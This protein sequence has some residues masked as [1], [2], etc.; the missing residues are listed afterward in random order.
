MSESQDPDAPRLRPELTDSFAGAMKGSTG[1]A[2]TVLRPS[3]KATID[4]RLVDVVSDG[5]F[6]PE[7]SEIE[8]VQVL[9]NRIVVREA[10]G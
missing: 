10:R 3:G 5:G 9:G 8:V 6:I 2:M 7:G 4:G 1:T